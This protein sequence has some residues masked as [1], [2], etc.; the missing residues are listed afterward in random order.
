MVVGVTALRLGQ[1]ECS[2][3]TGLRVIVGR[4]EEENRRTVRDSSWVEVG[5][6]EGEEEEGAGE[7]E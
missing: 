3:V 5:R 6:D 1:F 7:R 4:K 2:E